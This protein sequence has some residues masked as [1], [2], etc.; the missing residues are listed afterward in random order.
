MTNTSVHCATSKDF[1]TLL[2]MGEL[3]EARAELAR[4]KEKERD[5]VNQLLAVRAEI[6][7]QNVHIS[8]LIKVRRR[9]AIHLLPNEILISIFDLV[10]HDN[11][12]YSLMGERRQQLAGVSRKWRDLILDTPTLWSTIVVTKQDIKFTENCVKKS[13]KTLLDII[14]MSISPALEV[15]IS[16]SHRWRS[17]TLIDGERG[18]PSLGDVVVKKIEI[19]NLDFPSL[20]HVTIPSLMVTSYPNFLFSTRTPALEHLQVGNGRTWNDFYPVPTLKSLD[21]TFSNHSDYGRSFLY[22]IPTQS[23]TSLSLSGRI[24]TWIL[25]S[26]SIHFPHLKALTLR[27]NRMNMFLKAIV[28]PNLERFVYSLR[29]GNAR[30]S[31]LFNELDSKFDNV[32][33]FCFS[34]VNLKPNTTDAEALCRA[35]PHVHHVE[36]DSNGVLGLFTLRSPCGKFRA[37]LWSDLESLTL[38]K[39]S[40][41]WWGDLELF[42]SWLVER[43]RLHS[44][45]TRIK[46][47]GIERCG[48]ETLPRCFYYW[49]CTLKDIC[50]IELDMF[51]MT[52]KAN[53]YFGHDSSPMLVSLLSYL[54]FYGIHYFAA[55]L[56]PA[57][58]DNGRHCICILGRKYQDK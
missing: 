53:I 55:F 20:R 25:Q 34:S 41:S 51:P 56:R 54:S 52:F 37:D 48:D 49:H 42:Q 19:E 21:L 30:P 3:A 36:L 50:T 1:T 14:V 28:A 2:C 27:I 39:P 12:Y 16:Y 31:E 15:V 24:D 6:S 23:L 46:V 7:F 17:L 11:L 29:N 10:I 35:F 13:R 58:G 5:L 43:R 18:R 22:L 45:L 26:D 38:H 9:P 57:F 33:Y 8:S 44:R 4:L 32:H 40:A 47:T